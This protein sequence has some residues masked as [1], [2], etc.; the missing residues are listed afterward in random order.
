MYVQHLHVEEK[1]LASERMIQ[2]QKHSFFFFLLSLWYPTLTVGVFPV[3]L[4]AYFDF[5]RYI[6]SRPPIN[7]RKI[8]RPITVSWC[9]DH[10]LGFSNHHPFYCGLNATND[11][12]IA[13]RV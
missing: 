12:V 6:P 3:Q 9:H 11:L 10:M 7:R 4:H 2:V 13:L 5:F 1:R 8:V